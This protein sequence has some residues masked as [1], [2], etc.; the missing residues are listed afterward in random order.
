MRDINSLRVLHFTDTHIYA[1]A[2]HLF[3]RIDTQLSFLA[4]RDKALSMADNYDLI[5]VTGD[6]AA[7]AEEAAYRWLAEQLSVFALPIYCLPGNHDVNTVMEPLVNVAGWFFGGNHTVGGW[8]IVLLDTCVQDAAHGC[9]NAVEIER[10]DKALAQ[11][12]K[13]PTLVTL[14]HHPVPMMSAWMDTM[15]LNNADEF[16]QVIAKYPQVQIVLWG[17]VHQNFD[18]Y[19]NGVRLLATPSTCAQF[20]A[21]SV[22]FAIDSLTPGFRYLRLLPNGGVDTA[23]V[24][25]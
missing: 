3:A 1:D 12:P 19:R 6:L 25:T 2:A 23:V 18:T 10:L 13:L 17:H 21:R 24:R 20:A 15:Q 5:L 4:T 7:E 16:W 9:L 22:N 11:H 8:H 14:H